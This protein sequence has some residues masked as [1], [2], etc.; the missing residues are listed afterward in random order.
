VV[1]ALCYLSGLQYMLHRDIAARNFLVTHRAVIKLADF[2]CA[3][4]V[5]DDDYQATSSELIS[6]K[7]LAPEVLLH[8]RYST[9]SD[10]WAA[11]VVIWEILGTVNVSAAFSLCSSQ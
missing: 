8:S 11:G 1:S 5:H 7:W 4:L 10:L 2:A 9:S 6:V 3:R